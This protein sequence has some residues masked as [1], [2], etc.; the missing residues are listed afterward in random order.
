MKKVC[1]G[2][3]IKTDV[4]ERL[5]TFQIL[6]TYGIFFIVTVWVVP[7]QITAESQYTDAIFF[8][9]YIIWFS[10]QPSIKSKVQQD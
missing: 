9:T 3:I 6:L 2:L 7:P 10:I 5:L 1:V 4:Y 8:I